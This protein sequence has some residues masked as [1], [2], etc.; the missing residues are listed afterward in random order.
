M[1]YYD[2][3]VRDSEVQS[4]VVLALLK[5]QSFEQIINKPIRVVGGLFGAI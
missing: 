3:A 4:D 2:A 1:N 5:S